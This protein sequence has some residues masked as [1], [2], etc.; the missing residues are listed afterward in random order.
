MPSGL[1]VADASGVLSRVPLGALATGFAAVLAAAIVGVPALRAASLDAAEGGSRWSGRV[2]DAVASPAIL[3]VAVLCAAIAALTIVVSG[4]Q[5]RRDALEDGGAGI[6]AIWSRVERV[7]ALAVV[8]LTADAVA[9][10]VGVGLQPLWL[11]WPV[12][13]EPALVV[14]PTIAA[15]AAGPVLAAA[16]LELRRRAQR[17]VLAA[18]EA[19]ALERRTRHAVVGRRH[20]EPAR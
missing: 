18:A 7:S 8:G 11:T 4:Q 16:S 9:A 10:F 20:H 13:G 6:V 1:S 12:A 3:I 2:A 19:A 5:L 14:V 17:R 15:L